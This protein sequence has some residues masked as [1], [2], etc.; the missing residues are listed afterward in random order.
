MV[1]DMV[2]VILSLIKMDIPKTFRPEGNLDKRTEELRNH[3]KKEKPLMDLKELIYEYLTFTDF[4]K[5]NE[6]VHCVQIDFNEGTEVI[7]DYENREWGHKEL[8]YLEGADLGLS[9][10]EIKTEVDN[11]VEAID[12]IFSEN[13]LGYKDLPFN[14]V[15]FE[16]KNDIRI[17]KK[18][19]P[20]IVMRYLILGRV[21]YRY[22]DEGYYYEANNGQFF[23]VVRSKLDPLWH[24]IKKNKGIVDKILG[25]KTVYSKGIYE[26]LPFTEEEK[27]TLSELTEFKVRYRFPRPD[28]HRKIPDTGH[29]FDFGIKKEKNIYKVVMDVRAG[30]LNGLDLESVWLAKNFLSYINKQR[31]LDVIS[32]TQYRRY[33]IEDGWICRQPLKK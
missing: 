3:E 31:K 23:D 19:K 10:V 11:P 2:P 16:L 25:Y 20:K 21:G 6:H 8:R 30:F 14:E 32:E 27:E 12:A 29:L 5:E 1:Q 26:I 18:T 28:N 22:K 24:R 9:S 4:R 13:P 15:K 17:D 7:L 33:Y